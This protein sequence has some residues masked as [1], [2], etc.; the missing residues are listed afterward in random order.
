[1]FWF[2][3]FVSY[4]CATLSLNEILLGTPIYEI[5][6]SEFLCSGWNC[7]GATGSSLKYCWGIFGLHGMEFE[8][9][10]TLLKYFN[11]YF[12]SNT[13]YKI[14]NEKFIT[15]VSNFFTSY[16]TK[17]FSTLL[18]HFNKEQVWTNQIYVKQI[19]I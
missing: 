13:Y 19:R 9:H 7:L 2:S 14:C 8:N 12:S 1:M 10:W 15:Q 6:K 4:R 17:Q 18:F 16:L 5:E 11:E 3:N